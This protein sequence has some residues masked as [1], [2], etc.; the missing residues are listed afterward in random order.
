MGAT[1]RW[2]DQSV[3]GAI[4]QEFAEA[5]TSFH[6]LTGRSPGMRQ[7]IRQMQQMAPNLALATLEGEEGTGKTLAARALH[8]AGPAAAGPFVP[9]MASHFFRGADG[10]GDLGRPFGGSFGWSFGW[11]GELLAQADRGMLFLDRVH[12]LDGRQ[13]E[14]L[15]E[16][17]HYWENLRAIA[18]DDREQRDPGTFATSPRPAQIVVSASV[19]LQRTGQSPGERTAASINFP[20]LRGDLASKLGAVR[21]RLPP[22]R[23][24]RE[25]IPLLAQVFIQRF[26]LTYRKQVR[27]LGP[28]T[29]APLLRHVWA[30]NVRELEEAI[31][32][33]CVQTESQWLRPI[34][35]PPLASES[36]PRAAVADDKSTDLAEALNLDEVIRCH[37]IRV[38][39]RVRGNKLKAAQL[40]GI[41]RSTLY[42]ILENGR[43]GRSAAI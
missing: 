36:R 9:C 34:D 20:S 33:A 37:A 42:R 25:D 40:L 1:L 43:E 11:C 5:A 26:A 3:L 31:V 41:S 16:F 24:R 35:L 19:E 39:E 38:L 21:F 8:C 29:I 27:G 10:N 32:A 22:L 12:L 28:G 14:Q 13:Q 15:G 30:G 17:L 7:V 6:G 4:P 2:A 18:A 23:E